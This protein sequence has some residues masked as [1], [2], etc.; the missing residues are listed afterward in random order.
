ML[1]FTAVAHT[2]LFPRWDCLVRVVV[3][4]E[5]NGRENVS[6]AVDIDDLESGQKVPCAAADA[7]TFP[8]V[9][10]VKRK[11]A[12]WFVAGSVLM[13]KRPS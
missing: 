10:L 1:L 8:M 4:D 13:T 3:V 11:C 12:R 2:W 6:S 9:R 5:S 7:T